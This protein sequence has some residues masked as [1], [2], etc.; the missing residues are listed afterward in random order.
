MFTRLGAWAHVTIIGPAN[1]FYAQQADRLFRL[2]LYGGERVFCPCVAALV[3]AALLTRA[4]PPKA[5]MAVM[6][7][8]LEL[9]EPLAL[10]CAQRGATSR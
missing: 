5:P 3:R 1:N 10:S 6:P 2:H 8:R 9:P 4:R 7:T